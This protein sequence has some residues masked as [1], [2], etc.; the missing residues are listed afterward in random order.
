MWPLNTQSKF[1]L[2]RIQISQSPMR[3]IETFILTILPH[4]QQE[5]HGLRQKVEKQH[6]TP[7]RRMEFHMDRVS[8]KN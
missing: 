1:F 6:E 3:S 4:E 8:K 2:K 7:C 5:Q